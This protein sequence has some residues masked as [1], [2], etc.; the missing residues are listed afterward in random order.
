VLQ[1]RKNEI[2]LRKW[3]GGTGHLRTLGG[4]LQRSSYKYSHHSLGKLCWPKV[5]VEEFAP[6][7]QLYSVNKH[8]A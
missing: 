6:I 7:V 5:G 1:V 4:T 3:S 8:D 2:S